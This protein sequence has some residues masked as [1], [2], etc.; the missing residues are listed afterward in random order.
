MKNTATQ[1]EAIKND[2][3]F[4]VEVEM[5]HITR[6][7]AS[8]IAT[9]FLG[10]PGD[11]ENTA[12]RNGYMTW[13]A[14][15]LDNREWKFSK[16]SSIQAFREEEQCELIT[17]I[18]EYKDI[19]LLQDLLRK[20]RRAGAISEPSVGAGVHIHVARK[21]GFEVRDIK[22]LVNIMAS[23]EQQLVRAI[24]VDS[25]RIST[26]CK[27]VNQTFLS[28]MH[29]RKITTMQ[30]LEDCWYQTNDYRPNGT[31]CEHYNSSRYHMLNLHSFFNGHG[32]IE[33]RLF[34]FQNSQNGQRGGIYTEELKA[35]ILLCLGM[36]ELAHEST[37][38][39]AKPQQTEN[40]KY[41]LRCWLLRLGFIGDDFKTARQILLRNVDGSSAWR[42]VC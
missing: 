3:T 15:D 34:Q 14:Y 40:E 9:A 1:I 17:P 12:Y 28:E 39:S 22:N 38:T 13:S 24:N 21:N 27:P 18:L 2:Y 31:R 7:R 8:K 30:E 35:F 33:F 32:T 5:N 41:A 10:R 29:K 26:Y 36:C 19:P 42:R 16:D 25:D 37:K 4:G 20:L 23:H 6:K 11:Y